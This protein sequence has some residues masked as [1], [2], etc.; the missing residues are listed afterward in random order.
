MYYL[1]S[2]TR[3]AD[4]LRGYHAADLRLYS[5]SQTRQSRFIMTRLMSSPS[6]VLTISTMRSTGNKCRVRTAVK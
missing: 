2:E 1:C 3:G 5:S 6:Q 4:E